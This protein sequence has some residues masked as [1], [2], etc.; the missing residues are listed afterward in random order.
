MSEQITQL[1]PYVSFEGTCEEALNFYSRILNGT[2]TIEQRYDVPEMQAPEEYKDKILH[3]SMKFGENFLLASDMFPGSKAKK[4]SG[5]VALSIMTDN[6]EHG[7]TIFNALAE[8]GK[9]HHDFEKQFWG[10]WHGNLTDK[11]GIRWMVN[12]N[13]E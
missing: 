2:V 12:C 1:V 4:S 10:D 6:P 5:D 13:S 11:Y 7:R 9:V 3:A 8:E